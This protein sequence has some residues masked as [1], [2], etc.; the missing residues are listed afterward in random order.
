MSNDSGK[1]RDKT[2]IPEN[3]KIFAELMGRDLS[4]PK[5]TERLEKAMKRSDDKNWGRYK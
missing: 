5:V 3:V 4:D 2:E 1:K